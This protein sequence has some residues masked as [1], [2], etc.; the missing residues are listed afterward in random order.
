MFP[1]KS[2]EEIKSDILRDV[3]NL[4]PDAY[5]GQDSDF[6]VRA[7]STA[8]AIEGLYEHQEWISRQ[9]FPDTSD[10]DILERHAAQKGLTRLAAG[11]ATGTIN[12]SGTVGTP[13]P[14]ATEVKT[15]SGLSYLTTAPGVI[16]GAGTAVI[17]AQAVASGIAGNQVAATHLTLTAAPPGI[18]SD[19]TVAAMT[20]GTEIETP[21]SLLA[22]LL[23]ILQHPPAGGN[24]Y[25]YVRWAK[26]VPGVLN[27]YFYF[28]RRNYKS[29]DVVI[30]A[31]GGA[32]S[33]A[34]I[35]QVQA[36]IDNIRPVTHN[37]TLVLAATPVVVAV[38][39]VLTRSGV[40]LV[41]ATTAINSA[42]AIYFATLIPGDKVY[43][44]RITQIIMD[45]VG[46]V[47]VVLTA[48]AADV[49]CLIDQTHLELA[50]LGAVTLT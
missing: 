47:D 50:T 35:A 39:A 26:E 14:I 1:V 2:Y 29:I 41:D 27:A 10:I 18:N 28:A 15:D 21:A 9:I 5:V 17:A 30:T 49:V 7:S 19:A 32:P 25:D 13:V 33:G 3:V 46:L 8:A 40:T 31:V 6:N 16:G 44:T 24:Q 11:F 48:P 38:T 23:D 42:L 12:F 43:K 22:R 34:L 45:T 20:G 37:D 36:Y 4:A